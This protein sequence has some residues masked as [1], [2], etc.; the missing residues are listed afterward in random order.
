MKKN[1]APIQNSHDSFPTG[2]TK[3]DRRAP[4]V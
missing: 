4:K 2:F 3:V 1:M